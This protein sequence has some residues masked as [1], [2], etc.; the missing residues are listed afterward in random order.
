MRN[1][2]PER[3]CTVS[4]F[5]LGLD[6]VLRVYMRTEHVGEVRSK[7]CVWVHPSGSGGNPGDRQ[8]FEPSLSIFPKSFACIVQL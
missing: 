4:L 2:L 7:R 1:Q 6:S 8:S 5:A 3:S